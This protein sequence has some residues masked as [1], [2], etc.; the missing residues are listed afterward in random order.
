MEKYKIEKID[1]DKHKIPQRKC[2][3]DNIMPKFPFSML[4]SGPS[5]CG[6]TNLLINVMTKS[7]LYKDFFHY[8][9]VFSPTAG[10]LDDTYKALKLPKENFI[11]VISSEILKK[12]IE[13]RKQQIQKDGIEKVAKTSR[14]MIILDDVIA[15]K[16]FLN[17]DDAL[18]LFTLLRHYL[19]SVIVLVQAYN[20]VPKKMR[21]SCNAVA[22]FPSKRSEVE[23][24]K[25][26]ITP[27]G[28]SKKDFEKIINYCNSGEHTFLFINNHA[29]KDEKIRK[30]L[31]EVLTMDK[32]NKIINNFDDINISKKIIEDDSEEIADNL[33][34]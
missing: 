1:T 26:E 2:A 16:K 11:K 28:V 9:L 29:P 24:L 4:Y 13:K 33:T 5:G 15:N 23:V 31:D 32:I 19:V 18:M 12:I 8:V 30:N 21:N 25:E 20:A 7:T 17:S 10:E 6:K 27:A 22:V 34:V 3:I 14:M